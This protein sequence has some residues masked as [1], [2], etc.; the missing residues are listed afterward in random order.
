MALIRW[1]VIT[2]VAVHLFVAVAAGQG[3][4]R[5]AQRAVNDATRDLKSRDVEK[6]V[7][8]IDHL[9]TWG[10]LTTAPLIIG[11]LKDPDARVRAAAA[12][13]LWD[14]DMK[15]PAARAP[16]TAALDDPA[17]EVAVLAA[18]ADRKST[19]LNSSHGYI[20][21]AVVCLK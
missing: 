15:T 7:Q 6:R 10:K 18:G 9:A 11:A 5:T 3:L 17:P 19:R 20:S 2:A 21:Y 1:S 14:E 8:A 12:D 4:D 16:L 13:A